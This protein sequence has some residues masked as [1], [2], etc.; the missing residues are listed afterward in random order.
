MSVQGAMRRS[1]TVHL[2]LVE[3]SLVSTHFT[4]SLWL[5]TYDQ[6]VVGVIVWIECES[7]MERSG[8]VND[9]A[10]SEEK[11]FFFF[12]P[13]SLNQSHVEK[14]GI[15]RE[16]PSVLADLL[17]LQLAQASTPVVANPQRGFARALTSRRS[18][19]PSSTI[20]DGAQ[21]A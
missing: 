1:G 15:F 13:K 4:E 17:P 19:W 11:P 16:K 7:R 20:V 12:L 5:A 8:S 6:D 18:W 2:N 14:A 3:G 9:W 21:V 10:K